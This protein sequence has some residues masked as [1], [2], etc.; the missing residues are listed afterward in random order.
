VAEKEMKPRG[1]LVVI[2]SP[3]GGG[4]TTICERLLKKDPLLVR[5]I[6]ATTREPRGQ[7]R[8]GQDYFFM[9]P[10][11]FARSAKQGAFLEWAEVHGHCYGTPARE[12][13]RRQA[14]GHDVILTIDVQGGLNVKRQDPRAVLIFV[15]P[16]SLAVLQA[17]LQGRGTDSEET[18][19]RRLRNARWELSLAPAYDYNVVNHT[20]PEV[21]R[22]I[23]TI[24][25]AERL[26]TQQV[27]SS[28]AGVKSAG[29]GMLRRKHA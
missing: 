20:L 5:S 9:Q 2:S 13:R 28:G 21:V 11:A 27:K 15:K 16:P 25:A 26:R 23:G 29:A 4:K 7:E 6:S 8:A 10:A 24:I 12:V 14:Q 3:S 18:I 17:R 1:L 19:R 22:Q